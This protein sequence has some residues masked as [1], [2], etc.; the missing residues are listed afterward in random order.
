MNTGW[1]ITCPFILGIPPDDA[2]QRRLVNHAAISS[3][4][5]EISQPAGVLLPEL[6]ACVATSSL[7]E[8]V[9]TIDAGA[10]SEAASM[11]DALIG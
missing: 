10:L 9:G 3:G 5:V 2:P 11:V 1:V 7:G 6:V 4:V 8:S